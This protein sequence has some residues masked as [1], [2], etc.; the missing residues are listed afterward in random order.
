VRIPAEVTV[1]SSWVA[2]ASAGAKGT[3]SKLPMRVEISRARHKAIFEKRRLSVV[4]RSE[5]SLGD[6]EID[7]GTH[8]RANRS[9][10]D[11]RCFK[12]RRA[13]DAFDGSPMNIG[14][15]VSTSHRTPGSTIPSPF[16]TRNPRLSGARDR[17]PASSERPLAVLWRPPRRRALISAANRSG[18][19]RPLAVLSFQKG[20]PRTFF[21]PRRCPLGEV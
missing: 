18:R 6:A 14:E 13:H 19:H 2:V 21:A 5:T 12:K 17:L 4:R 1:A 20:R 11:R 3:A 16:P 7:L 9:S 8:R 15:G 10:S